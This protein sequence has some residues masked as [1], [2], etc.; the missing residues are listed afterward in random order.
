M[1]NKHSYL[2]IFEA[3]QGGFEI[4]ARERSFPRTDHRVKSWFGRRHEGVIRAV[5]QLNSIATATELLARGTCKRS[6]CY[7]PRNP[8]PRVCESPLLRVVFLRVVAFYTRVAQSEGQFVFQE[9]TPA[10]HCRFDIVADT[11]F[12]HLL[13]FHLCLFPISPLLS[14]KFHRAVV[15]NRETDFLQ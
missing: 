5:E 10:A 3:E 1:V 4:D 11:I 13:F 6:R 8:F 2:D 15:A 14:G 7:G 12:I 9:V